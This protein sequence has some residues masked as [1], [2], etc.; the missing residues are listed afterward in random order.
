MIN[1]NEVPESGQKFDSMPEN[2]YT[3]RVEKA[4][5]ADSKNGPNTMIKAQ[6]AVVSPAKYS[7]RKVWNNFNLGS[8]SLWV[9]KNFFEAAGIDPNSLGDISEQQLAT[10]MVDLVVDGYLEPSTTNTGKPSNTIKNYRP[11]PDATVIPTQSATKG[12]MFK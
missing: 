2:W 3:I 10:K 11:V 9:L 7:K 4:E 12:A 1:F 6:F 5:L 8:K